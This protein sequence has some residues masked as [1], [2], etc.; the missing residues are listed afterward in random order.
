MKISL[1]TF[2]I[3]VV[4]A[5]LLI[6]AFIT[7]YRATAWGYSSSTFAASSFHSLSESDRLKVFAEFENFMEAE[8]FIST[9]SPS[10]FDSWAGVHSAESKRIWF[11]RPTS[12]KSKLY[13]YA[14][15]DTRA[16]RTSIKWEHNG[17]QSGADNAKR[18]AL[19]FAIR[20]NDWIAKLPEV[21][22][23]PARHQSRN[24]QSLVNQVEKLD[25]G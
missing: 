13:L 2:L 8:G 10:E 24:R 20:V 7:L 21:N 15:L 19:D 23:L 5:S 11:S 4:V 6:A 1:R 22:H 14:D 3:L 18:E 25:G 17:F 16:L 9:S 12:G